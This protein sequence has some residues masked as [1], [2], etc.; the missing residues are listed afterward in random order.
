MSWLFVKTRGRLILFL[1][2]W[3]GCCYLVQGFKTCWHTMPSSDYLRGIYNW[4]DDL[5]LQKIEISIGS[6]H[7]SNLMGYLEISKR[8]GLGEKKSSPRGSFSKYSCFL[9]FF[10]LIIEK[11]GSILWSNWLQNLI[12]LNLCMCSFL[13]SLLI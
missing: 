10:G 3:F 5:R 9:L 12:W 2:L 13:S 6:Y 7:K 1:A 8:V 4:L 11:K